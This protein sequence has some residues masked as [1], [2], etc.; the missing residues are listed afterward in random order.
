M[1][2]NPI[3]V[4]HKFSFLNET[5]LFINHKKKTTNTNIT[6]TIFGIDRIEHEAGV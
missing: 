1:Y 2:A 5:A 3:C 4:S 6:C